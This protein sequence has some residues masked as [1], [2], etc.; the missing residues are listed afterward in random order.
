[1]RKNI[2]DKKSSKKKRA[3][4]NGELETLCKEIRAADPSILS[5][6][7]AEANGDILAHSFGAGYERE[8]LEKT[9]KVRG[10][11]GVWAALML[12]MEYEVEQAFGET[13]CIVRIHKKAKLM[14]VP[15]AS[16]KMILT[17]LT[18]RDAIG[19]DILPKILPL[20]QSFS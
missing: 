6:T 17:M 2:G 19:I 9:S 15:F 10:R 4:R 7:I 18:T 13:E 11:A 16:K 1:M 5:L 12:G 3:N 20:L 14:V 8:F